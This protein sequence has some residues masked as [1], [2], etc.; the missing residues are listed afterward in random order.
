MKYELI[1]TDKVMKTVEAPERTFEFPCTVALVT[2]GDVVELVQIYG[3]RPEIFAFPRW[4]GEALLVAWNMRA[5][6]EDNFME[7]LSELLEMHYDDIR[8]DRDRRAGEKLAK[9]MTLVVPQMCICGHDMGGHA[10]TENPKFSPCTDSQCACPSFALP[11][12]Y[13]MA[14][15]E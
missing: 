14:G 11:R 7:D 12:V 6:F 13:K 4:I 15:A 8:F 5:N 3:L 9:E 2:N 1:W 10:E